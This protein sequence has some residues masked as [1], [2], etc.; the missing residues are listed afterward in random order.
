MMIVPRKRGFTLIEL[1]VVIA[2]IAILAA[3]LLP[4]LSRARESARRATCINN[5]KQM[6]L[7]MH[8]FIQDNNEFMPESHE[9]H[10]ALQEYLDFEE[11]V[12]LCPSDRSEDWPQYAY[13]SNAAGLKAAQVARPTFFALL[14]DRQPGAGSSWASS[15]DERADFFYAVCADRHGGG[16]NFLFLEGRVEW[17]SEPADIPS[18]LLTFDPG[19]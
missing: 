15:P 6:G 11:D 8:M 14:F 18:T 7:S 9:W 19:S 17:L 16:T 3:L 4:A 5:L 13:N 12:W 2:V 10:S 1:L